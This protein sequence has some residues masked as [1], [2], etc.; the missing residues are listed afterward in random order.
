MSH[1]LGEVQH[2]KA[3]LGAQEASMM[4]WALAVL[5]QLNPT[6]WTALL[7]VIAAAPQESLDEVPC[8]TL[9][10]VHPQAAAVWILSLR[11]CS[12]KGV[13]PAAHDSDS[14]G[15]QVPGHAIAAMLAFWMHCLDSSLAR[16][17]D[18]HI[19]A[20]RAQAAVVWVS[21]ILSLHTLKLM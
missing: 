19:H 15:S 17:A 11:P 16:Q 21:L 5:H 9:S 14:A 8:H 13:V 7:D 20:E 3:V 4:V 12:L 6:I 2:G 18:L 10:R 1:L